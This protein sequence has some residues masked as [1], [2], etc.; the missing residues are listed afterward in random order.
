M[1][2]SLY[3][4]QVATTFAN[5]A[6]R[7]VE[8][9]ND[10]TNPDLQS[11]LHRQELTKEY[12]PDLKW[13][14]LSISESIIAADVI[15]MDSPI[16]LKARDSMG[17]ATGTI[18]KQAIEY[19][20]REKELTDLGILA[21]TPGRQPQLLQRLFND[22][23]RS[24]VGQYETQEYQYLLGLSSGV[25]VI[26][27]ANNV[28]TGIRV[29]YGYL[30]ANKFGVSKLWSDPTSTP[31]SDLSK[32]MLAKARLDGNTIRFVRLDQATFDNI[33]KTQEAKD[34]FAFSL[35]VI[36]G[37]TNVTVPS[38]DQLNNAARSRYGFVFEIMERSVRFQKNGV[39]TNL[40]P[41]APGM[42]VGL[43]TKDLGRQVWGTLA[44]M[45]HPAKQVTY[46]T[47]DDFILVSKYHLVKPSLAEVTNSQA[48][49]LPVI[50]G[51]DAIYQMDSTSVTA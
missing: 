10:S 7:V 15:A 18:P 40:K 33:A 24:I 37:S 3:I 49:V 38:F 17:Q 31:F 2:Q 47:V 45:E 44:E 43:I 34:L 19:Q 50:D 30:A 9:L 26:A 12:S 32:R 6:Q 8:R 1:E 29:D 5:Y 51:V 22:T 28:G 48:L 39:N 13:G 16:P 27:D 41:W 4:D 11:Y 14:S 36:N 42:V 35:G 23:K 46:A 21:R 20:M 25:T